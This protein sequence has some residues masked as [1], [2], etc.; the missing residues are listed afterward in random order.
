MKGESG[1]TLLELLVVTAIIGILASLAIANYSIFKEGAFNTTAASDARNIAP[2]AELASSQ[3]VSLTVPPEDGLSPGPIP[4]LPGAGTSFGT[5]ATF[6]ITA[7][8]YKIQT[9]HL[10]G[11]VCYT[12]ENGSMSQASSCS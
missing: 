4:E 8:S 11:N 9:Y 10:R 6:D 5:A 12:M 1:F 2:A 3:G 7:N